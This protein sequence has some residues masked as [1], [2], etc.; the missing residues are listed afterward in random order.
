MR[1]VLIS[2]VALLMA[3]S[4]NA[5][6]L[7][8]STTP[9]GAGKLYFNTSLSGLNL[10]YDFT[11]N[12]SL[13]VNAKAGCMFQDNWMVLADVQWAVRQDA[14]NDFQAGA[15]IRYYIEQNGLYLGVGAHY[16]HAVGYDDFLPYA[17]LGYAFFLSR[18]VTIEPE[19]Y[20]DMSTK[21]FKDNSGF[22]FRIGF[23][24]YLE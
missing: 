10:N 11:K 7:N 3:M 18:T 1:K 15:G 14:P 19:V 6:Y 2:M 13:D 24:V 5:Q 12:W 17:S 4:A 20:Y 9:F 23:G 21:S 8:D 22:G 16:K